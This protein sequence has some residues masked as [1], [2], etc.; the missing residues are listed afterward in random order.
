MGVGPAPASFRPPHSFPRPAQTS[1]PGALPQRGARPFLPSACLIKGLGQP[2]TS[3]SPTS[4]GHRGQALRVAPS[5]AGPR[6][7]RH[8]Q[9]RRGASLT[10]PPLVQPPG[11][12]WFT[13]HESTF[14]FPA[15]WKPSRVALSQNQGTLDGHRLGSGYIRS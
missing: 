14:S 11:G 6:P 1:P 15:S 2:C 5:R 10:R 12:V 8:R 7:Q 4:Q 13:C 3:I 9:P